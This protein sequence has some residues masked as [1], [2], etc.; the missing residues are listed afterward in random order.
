MTA[1][2]NDHNGANGTGIRCFI[3][4]C[5]NKAEVTMIDDDDTQRLPICGYCAI[6][7]LTLGMTIISEPGTRLRI[8]CEPYKI[9]KHHKQ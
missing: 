6:S 5:K 7:K 4:G 8:I 9:Q 3:N 1:H 2:K